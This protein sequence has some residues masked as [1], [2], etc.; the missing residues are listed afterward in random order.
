[1]ILKINNLVVSVDK[2]IILKNINLTLKNNEISILMG[3]NGSG[4]STLGKVLAGHSSYKILKGNIFLNNKDITLIKPEIRFHEGLF[5]AFQ[6]PLEIFGVTLFDFLLIAFNE[7]QKYL[8]KSEIEPVQFIK[9]VNECIDKLKIKKEFLT[10]NLNEGFS[11]GEKK[12]IEILQ[13]LLFKPK[14]I[15]L[16]EIDSGLDIDAVQ[17]IYNSILSFKEKEASVILISH[18]TQILDY[19]IPNYVNIL[20]NGIII[21]KGNKDL[22][23]KIKTT[24]YSIF[25][26]NND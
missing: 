9:N 7:K 4:K 22:V 10:R 18:N 8:N 16:D 19:I 2:K 21:K 26:Q 6:Y 25:K 5:L 20:I 24:G 13:M 15:I 14:L 12:R 3:P 23:E 11:G 1:M 17:L